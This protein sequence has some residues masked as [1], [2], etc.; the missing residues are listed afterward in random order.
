MH[1]HNYIRHIHFFFQSTSGADSTNLAYVSV[2]AIVL[3]YYW[4]VFFLLQ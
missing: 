2:I 4:L 1:E 3:F